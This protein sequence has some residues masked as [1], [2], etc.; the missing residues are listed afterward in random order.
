MSWS[1]CGG[2]SR[3]SP[4]DLGFGPSGERVRSTTEGGGKVAGRGTTR[5]WSRRRGREG[6]GG[7]RRRCGPA[8]TFSSSFSPGGRRLGRCDST[9]GR[10]CPGGIGQLHDLLLSVLIV[11]VGGGQQPAA[12][13]FRSPRR[14]GRHQGLARP[15]AARV[16]QPDGL[17]KANVQW[18]V[19][20]IDV[21]HVA[22]VDVERP[23]SAGRTFV[24]TPRLAFHVLVGT[25]DPVGPNAAL[26]GRC[27]RPEPG[28]RVPRVRVS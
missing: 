13:A 23:E 27:P 1:T 22:V 24:A 14:E 4:M 3:S 20:V 2:V 11:V 28:G 16:A 6:S 26:Q 9:R 15:S 12:A 18:P 10:S 21:V 8:G 17:G 25:H 5:S 19:H 7:S